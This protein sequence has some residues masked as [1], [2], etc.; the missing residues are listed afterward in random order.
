MNSSA[1]SY[2]TKAYGFQTFFAALHFKTHLYY[3]SY[4]MKELITVFYFTNMLIF[5][6][7]LVCVCDSQNVAYLVILILQEL[8]LYI[9][10]CV[11]LSSLSCLEISQFNLV[12]Q[13]F[14]TSNEV[15]RYL[16]WTK[17][18]TCV[19]DLLYKE[20]THPWGLGVLPILQREFK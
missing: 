5:F 11:Y 8:A 16:H 12:N 20:V 17:C 10:A 2:S 19:G 9:L 4:Q 18:Y 3:L 6:D 15:I 1:D 7:K 13:T 14:F